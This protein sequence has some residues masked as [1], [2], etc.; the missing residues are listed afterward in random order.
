LRDP[1]LDD[2]AIA[3][4]ALAA[5]VFVEPLSTRHREQPVRHGLVLGVG[6]VPADRV[7]PGVAVLAACL[8]RPRRRRP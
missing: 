1:A 3:E 4:Q 8:S 7:G 2:V 5:G 6:A